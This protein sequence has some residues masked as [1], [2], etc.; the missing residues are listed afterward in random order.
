[1]VQESSSE[2]E[3]QVA[4]VRAE[5]ESLLEESKTQT[6]EARTSLT[7]VREE[8]NTAQQQ[9]A[10]LSA[11]QEKKAKEHGAQTEVKVQAN[12]FLLQQNGLGLLNKANITFKLWG[13]H[14]TCHSY[15]FYLYTGFSPS[16]L[17]K[18]RF[19]GSFDR[20]FS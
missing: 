17:A 20:F 5:L 12:H 11:E 16:N 3:N 6:E 4:T 15:R 19:P 1:M 7:A 9:L 8:L 14:Q 2:T 18:H 10:T 13:L